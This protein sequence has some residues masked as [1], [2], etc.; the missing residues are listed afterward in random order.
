V[1][2][3][4]LVPAARISDLTKEAAIHRKISIALQLCGILLIVGTLW[5][6]ARPNL[7]KSTVKLRGPGDSLTIAATGDSLAP[8][9]LP[10]GLADPGFFG[11]VDVLENASLGLTTLEQNLLG[12]K[13]HSQPGKLARWP[14]GTSHQAED[15]RRL[16]MTV[17]SLA[18]N[19]AIDYGIEGMQATEDILS[20]QGLFHVG[21]GNN[22]QLAG[23]PVSVGAPPRC[24]A[25]IAV[26]T[27]A[28]AESRATYTQGEIL[29][30]PGV[31]ALRYS[32]QVT[33]DH[34]AFSSLKR[35]PL[36]TSLGPSS[37]SGR[38]QLMLSGTV[39]TEGQKTAVD[40]VPNDRD[41]QGIL[42]QV[43]LARSKCGDIVVMLHSHEPSNQSQV[44]SDFVQTFAR[45][46][47]D[48]GASLVVGSGPHQLRGIEVH[49]RGVI[50]YSL[51][52][53]VFDYNAI[54]SRAADVYE[55]GIDLQQLALGAVSDFP[56]YPI[57]H[58]EEPIW[59]ESV[60]AIATFNNGVLGSIR[61]QP[62]DLGVDL[63][64]SQRG[65]PRIAAPGR[66]NEILQ[67]LANL[68][69]PLGT[70][71]RVKDG[72]GFI[73]LAGVTH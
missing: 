25:V 69:R 58:F 11:V 10:F 55:S 19:H 12:Q 71:V 48:A 49:N 56:S 51:G 44:A 32:P 27:S 57:P 38:N 66:G 17:I 9:P 39:I 3:A 5:L 30:R 15:L 1:S 43:R 46:L 16:G 35:S 14:Y 7:S 54:D 50:F 42:G 20:R 26:T 45:A 6:V 40:F 63:P 65:I 31:N 36:A 13:N 24:V 23:T 61:L 72:M 59:W 28:N 53:F 41:L 67:R 70:M 62:I 68:S 29:G 47:V 21:S 4:I 22:L 33:A 60:I 64:V 8:D 73:D 34:S 37:A 52:N 2:C 18:N